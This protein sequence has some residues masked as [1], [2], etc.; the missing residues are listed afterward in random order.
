MVRAISVALAAS[1]CLGVAYAQTPK[2]DDAERQS[3]LASGNA[4]LAVLKDPSRCGGEAPP[5]GYACAVML[6]RDTRIGG[7]HDKLPDLLTVRVKS[8]QGLDGPPNQVKVVILSPFDNCPREFSPFGMQAMRMGLFSSVSSETA[9][10]ELKTML[11]WAEN[12]ALPATAPRHADPM[13][14]KLPRCGPR[15]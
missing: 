9:T 13:V 4:I 2:P 8:V 14:F 12:E 1:V 6:Y 5:P 11:G 10:M 7:L 3:F 15:H